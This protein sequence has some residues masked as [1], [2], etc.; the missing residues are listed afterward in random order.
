[1]KALSLFTHVAAALIGA[2]LW[3]V[4]LALAP[5][6]RVST[7]SDVAMFDMYEEGYQ[8]GV[9]VTVCIEELGMDAPEEEVIHCANA[10]REAARAETR[11]QKN[12]F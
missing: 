5:E 2:V 4:S 3:A 1:M 8:Q 7:R 9:A 11:T 10:I 6:E 12:S